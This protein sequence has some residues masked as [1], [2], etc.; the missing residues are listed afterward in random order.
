MTIIKSKLS[1]FMDLSQH[2]VYFAK[3]EIHQK[4]SLNG[5]T[6]VNFEFAATNDT[7]WVA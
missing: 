5:A 3:L 4:Q 2:I 7:L 1:Y 6:A